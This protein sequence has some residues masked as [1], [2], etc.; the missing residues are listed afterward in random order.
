LSKGLF[1]REPKL[2]RISISQINMYDRC[3]EQY[4][5]RYI[6]GRKIPPSGLMLQGSVYHQ[7]HAENFKQKI[8]TMKDLSTS[9]M[10]D[11]YATFWDRG[12]DNNPNYSRD[13]I[14]WEEE[15]RKVKDE[16]YFLLNLYHTTI[17]STIIPKEVETEKTKVI[18]RDLDAVGIL[19]L[20]KVD[21]VIVDH[22]VSRRSQSQQDV[23]RDLQPSMYLWINDKEQ[24]E[25]HRAVNKKNPEIQIL[26]TKRSQ[27]QRERF[28][29]MIKNIYALI[30][31]GIFVPRCDTF[32]CSKNF[33]GYFEIC[34]ARLNVY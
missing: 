2:N 13:E 34:K 6:L 19:D 10:A 20:I 24:F 4:R 25:F 29:E 7:A 17:S 12:I 3:P 16:G 27:Q 30:Q 23:D 15:P 5:Q 22:K 11:A 8:T 18:N 1:T 33:C 21:D 26:K 31:T 28:V 14:V 9:D 32:W